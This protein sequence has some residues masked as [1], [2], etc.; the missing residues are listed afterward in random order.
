[1][2]R[3][4]RAL[5]LVIAVVYLLPAA[6]AALLYALGSHPGSWRDADWSSAALLPT[7]ADDRAAAVYVLAARTGGLKGA[8]AEHSWI[9]LKRAGADRYERFDKVGWGS[10]IRRNGY[11]ADGRWYSNEPRLVTALHG[12]AATSAIP[13]VEAAIADY[14][15]AARGGYRIFPG[16]NSNSFV[17]H[18]LRQVP[19]LGA[20]LPP[21]AVGRDFP[22]D[23]RIIDLDREG[24][25][26]SLSLFGYAGLRIGE[27]SGF[28]VNLL[29]LVAG[30]DP[31]RMT[32]KIPAFGSLSLT[33]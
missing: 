9:V 13:A 32:V 29:G 27:R 24:H 31:F 4:L 20:V 14:P 25:E 16:P 1:M 5:L 3:I 8:L 10:P 18:V 21:A 6:L 30:L 17:A 23:G 11:P 12:D 33:G 28:E 22:V 19:A 26:L 2:S 15:F 7:A